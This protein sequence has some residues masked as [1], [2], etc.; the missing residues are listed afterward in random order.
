MCL[1]SEV[2]ISLSFY[3]TALPG[4]VSA[5]DLFSV[6]SLQCLG[7]YSIKVIPLLIT[8]YNQLVTIKE[9]CNIKKYKNRLCYPEQKIQDN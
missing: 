2:Y 4:A 9:R 3:P 5:F 7:N 1:K 6:A 8:C